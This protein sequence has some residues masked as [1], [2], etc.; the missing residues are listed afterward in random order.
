MTFHGTKTRPRTMTA[1]AHV[2]RG[3][4]RMIQE[5]NCLPLV[6][7]GGKLLYCSSFFFFLG[8]DD[9]IN[10]GANIVIGQDGSAF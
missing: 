7:R 1:L 2:C 6:C 5:C 10:D 3:G 8:K 4:K 9:R